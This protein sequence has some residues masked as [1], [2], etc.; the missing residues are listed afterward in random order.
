V[1]DA[2][3]SVIFLFFSLL[4]DILIYRVRVRMGLKLGM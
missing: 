4:T 2:D 1:S 3:I